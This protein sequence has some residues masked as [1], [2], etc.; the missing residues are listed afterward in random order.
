MAPV[1]HAQLRADSRSETRGCITAATLDSPHEWHAQISFPVAFDLLAT[2]T[3]VGLAPAPPSSPTPPD[4]SI[5]TPETKVCASSS[6]FC[7]GGESFSCPPPAVSS[8][9]AVVWASKL[10]GH[11]RGARVGLRP[12]VCAGIG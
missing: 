7:S 6:F 4:P 11:A 10:G 2:A 8:S 5:C 3:S 9:S 1:A 12:L